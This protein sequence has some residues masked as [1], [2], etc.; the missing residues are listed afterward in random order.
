MSCVGTAW[1][2]PKTQVAGPHP[3]NCE[4]VGLGGAPE[5]ALVTC[6]QQMW[7]VLV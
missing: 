6:F 4:P 5:C 2:A 3:R 7:M 1:K